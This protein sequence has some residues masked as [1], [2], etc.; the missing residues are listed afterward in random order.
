M[1]EKKGERDTVI[2]TNNEREHDDPTEEEIASAQQDEMREMAHTTILT[3]QEE[4]EGRSVE[5]IEEQNE[6]ASGS[7]E[8]F[9]EAVEDEAGEMVEDEMPTTNSIGYI[10][11]LLSKV[12]DENG[13]LHCC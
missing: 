10:P 13:Y 6:K 3:V 5:S 7:R 8:Q 4:D 12:F 9:D 11:E 1:W 2:A